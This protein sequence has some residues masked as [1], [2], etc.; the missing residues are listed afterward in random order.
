MTLIPFHAC[1]MPQEGDL[2]ALV[3][4]TLRL[5]A[6]LHRIQA[7]P[8][9]PIEYT[10]D[11]MRFALYVPG[12][13]RPERIELS[14]RGPHR[15]LSLIHEIGHLLDHALGG[16]MIYSS[17]QASSP[18]ADV[19]QMIDRSR[20]IQNF[21]SFIVHNSSRDPV[22]RQITYWLAPGEQWARA[23]AQFV[24][25]QSDSP[26]LQAEL[27][28]ARDMEALAVNKNVQWDRQDFEPILEAMAVAFR[29]MGWLQ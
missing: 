24:A 1:F 10:D 22:V 4:E 7:I 8:C 2:K 23:Y 3:E 5:I 11:E 6:S 29:N 20:A 26:A 28:F 17:S 18:L 25:T 21:R 15:R 14:R 19:M 12:D 27:A 9:I 13:G 16:Y